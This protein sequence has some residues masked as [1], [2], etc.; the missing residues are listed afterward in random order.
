MVGQIMDR[1]LR[2]IISATA[3]GVTCDESTVACNGARK[4][5]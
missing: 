1:T 3:F 2:S 5:Q 4:I